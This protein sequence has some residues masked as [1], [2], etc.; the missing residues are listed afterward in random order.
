[1]HPAF[2]AFLDQLRDDRGASPHTVRSYGD[3]LAS[4][5][6]FL[7]G[8]VGV[9]ADPLIVD[10]RRLRSY[11]AW[12]SSREYA[13]ST[14]ARRLASLRSFFK[15]QRRRG[16]VA[17]DPTASLRNP[18]QPRRLPGP[19]RV[20]QVLHLLEAIPTHDPLGIR[21]RA[22]FEAPLWRRAACFRSRWPRPGR[23]RPRTAAGPGSGKRTSR[24]ALSSRSCRL[25]V[26]QSVASGSF[27][28]PI[29]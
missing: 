19:L 23:S 4:F 7:E 15:F 29:E 12:L 16:V 26:A 3:D 22:L 2:A 24:A 21:D 20:D 6:Q 27:T 1:M 17:V 25:R 11:A 10:A 13:P 18:K 5:S 28:V 9:D 14:I 8:A